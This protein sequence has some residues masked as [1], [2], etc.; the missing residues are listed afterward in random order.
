MP[1][2]TTMTR[3]EREELAKIIRLRAKVTKAGIETAAADLRADVERQ[4]SQIHKADADQWKDITAEA[5]RFVHDADAAI[6]RICDEHGIPSDFRPYLHLSWIGRGENASAARR[7]ELRKV[8]YARIDA[9]RKAGYQLV[10]ARAADALTA[11]ASG[12]L[13][14]VE[15]KAFLESL[16]TVDA[17]MPSVRVT[18]ELLDGQST[19]PAPNRL[20]RSRHA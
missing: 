10:D 13:T 8:A 19:T 7:A 1:S 11:L 16:P 20:L 3:S 12:A 6:A 17:L 5:D 2:D 18:A 15:A 4:L 14:S 9:D